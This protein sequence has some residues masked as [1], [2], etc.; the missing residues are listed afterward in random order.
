MEQRK[1]ARQEKAVRER[2]AVIMRVQAGLMTA[3]EGAKQLGISRKTYYE[4]E[5]R[6]L[7]GMMSAIHPGRTGRP[8]NEVDIEKRALEKEIRTLRQQ[9]ALN[10]MKLRIRDLFKELDGPGSKAADLKKTN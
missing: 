5:T 2:T 4:L 10:Q 6:A 3:T 7:A 8:K 1:T 9:V